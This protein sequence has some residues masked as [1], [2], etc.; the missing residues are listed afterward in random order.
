MKKVI[1]LLLAIIMAFS[2]T[3]C[4]SA[5]TLSQGK[6]RATAEMGAGTGVIYVELDHP[7]EKIA[8]SG[9]QMEIILPAG[10]FF[11]G[12]VS[13][14][15]SWNIVQSAPYKVGE[16]YAKK[17]SIDC[18]ETTIPNDS[19]T[20]TVLNIPISFPKNTKPGDY[21]GTINITDIAI[22]IGG[23]QYVSGLDY[24]EKDNGEHSYPLNL[25]YRKYL[26]SATITGIEDM[27]YTGSQR[28]PS[29]TVMLDG[30]SLVAKTDYTVSYKNNTSCGL[31][32][33]VVTGIGNYRGSISKNFYIIPESLS[34][35]TYGTR[36]ANSIE[37][38]WSTSKNADG[39]YIHRSLSKD[40]GYSIVKTIT[41]GST[42]SYVDT[43]LLSGTRYYYK[44]QAYKNIG[45]KRIAGVFPSAAPSATT[46]GYTVNT[47][48]GL[49]VSKKTSTSVTLKWN[50]TLTSNDGKVV[51]G[52]Y[53]YRSTAANS[54]YSLVATVSNGETLTYKDTGLTAGK[55]YYY[56]VQPY[57]T[58]KGTAGK[59]GYASLS[60]ATLG[61]VGTVT[62]LKKSSVK[63]GS[64]K[65][66][67]SGVSTANGYEIYHSLKKGSGYSLVKTTTSTSFTHSNL[68]SGTN[69]Y[70]KVRAYRNE[71]GKKVYG[72]FSSVFTV[73]TTGYKV[74]KPSKL[75]LASNSTTS[76]KLSWK[77]VSKANGY[78][79]YRSTS[80]DTGY[81][82]IKT[83][84]KGGT[85]SFT[86]KKLTAGKT[87]YY[88]VVAYRTYKGSKGIGQYAAITA[89]TKTKAPKITL[90]K[91][92][93]TSIKV[94]AK[95]VTGASGYQIY[96]STKKSSGYKK[97]YTGSKK[98]Y[99]KKSLKKGKKYYVKVR[100]YKTIGG[101]KYYSSYSSVKSIKL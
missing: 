16:Q 70:Y 88:R 82:K 8:I 63:I 41:N 58:Y 7:T 76:I 25:K 79:I 99:T 26:T 51:T 9:V 83:I 33:V 98:T 49:A 80:K 68:C 14:L 23:P 2:V 67:W 78:Y 44:A 74:S 96:Y 69:N 89:G 6:F 28:T 35:V 36:T 77:K 27:A 29:P 10:I 37:V 87:Y 53:I 15:K 75:K 66:S 47:T 50:K 97:A 85:V 72:S 73:K 4:I 61:K 101:K 95:K 55:T 94:T 18:V 1:S 13:S 12:N 81:K 39:Y 60:V 71:D 65:L 32:T 62:G 57:R 100:A 42:S 11:G 40:G 43:D 90:K 52:Y 24:F 91:A 34:G 30:V 59:G 93:K 17:V 84:T 54:G 86:N 64:T 48:T 3:P 31:A 21:S 45:G 20:V 56:R 5:D 19:S 38:K 46:S 92:S 22:D